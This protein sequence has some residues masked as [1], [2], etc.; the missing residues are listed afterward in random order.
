MLGE[1][2]EVGAGRGQRAAGVVLGEPVEG[3]HQGVPALL[4]VALEVGREAVGAGHSHGVESTTVV[5][6]E[7]W[8]APRTCA[9]RSSRAVGV[10]T[11]TLRM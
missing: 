11:R 3:A 10:S 9:M 5:R 7:T 2:E 6:V 8:A 4:E 1:A